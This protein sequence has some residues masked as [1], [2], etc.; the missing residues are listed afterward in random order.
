MSKKGQ[1]V[2]MTANDHL[3]E[4]AT[5]IGKIPDVIIVNN[6]VFPDELLNKYSEEGDFPVLNNCTGDSCTVY[7]ESLVAMENI[8]LVSGDVLKRSLI[9]HDSDILAS[10]LIKLV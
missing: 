8:Q 4:V 6:T 3:K 10:I 9:R 5:Y 7:A 1:T 2:G